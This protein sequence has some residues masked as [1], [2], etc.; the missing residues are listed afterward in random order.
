[1][2]ETEEGRAGEDEEDPGGGRLQGDRRTTETPPAAE[3]Q[4]RGLVRSRG[5]LRDGGC[6][7][8]YLVNCCCSV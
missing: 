6:R 4:R 7:R 2:E 3:L 1:M 8:F 5:G